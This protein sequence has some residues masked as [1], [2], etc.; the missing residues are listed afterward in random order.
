MVLNCRQNI[1]DYYAL[2]LYIN[3][4]SNN[5]VTNKIELYTYYNK[6]DKLL[7]TY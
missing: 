2:I 1:K 7:H 3:V 5:L 6:K 4:K